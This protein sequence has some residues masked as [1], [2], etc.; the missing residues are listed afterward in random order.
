MLAHIILYM[1]YFFYPFPE[2]L[3]LATF[4]NRT[5]AK[6]DILASFLYHKLEDWF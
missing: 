3:L 5:L 1:L 6:T 2:H 4:G